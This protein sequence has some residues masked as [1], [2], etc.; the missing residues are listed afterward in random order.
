MSLPGNG[1]DVNKCTIL[2][3]KGGNSAPWHGE[4]RVEEVGGWLERK[5]ERF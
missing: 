3:A 4:R 2:V 5:E 1:L